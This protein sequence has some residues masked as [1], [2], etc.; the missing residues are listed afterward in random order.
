MPASADMKA[1]E[2][3]LKAL[4]DAQKALVNL[5]IDIAKARADVQIHHAQMIK[6]MAQ[7]PVNPGLTGEY[8]KQQQKWMKA[9]ETV[10]KLQVKEPKLHTDLAKATT[11]LGKAAGKIS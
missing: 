6:F 11:A 4:T 8:V 7:L 3:A 2:K 9:M 1:Y 10:A 5:Q